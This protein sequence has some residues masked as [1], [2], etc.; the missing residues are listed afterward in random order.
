M[1]VHSIRCKR[2]MQIDP[3]N[4]AQIHLRHTERSCKAVNEF[5]R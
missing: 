4:A 3:R 1:F 2:S 5:L